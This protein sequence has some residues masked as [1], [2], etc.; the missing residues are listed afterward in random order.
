M[1]MPFAIALI[2][3]ILGSSFYMYREAQ[4]VCALPLSYRIGFIDERF[5]LSETEALSAIADA[6]RV[7]EQG[8]G[9]DIFVYQPE[10]EIEINFVYDEQQAFID[11]QETLLQKLDAS[12]SV[13]DAIDQT[14]QELEA[15]FR[16]LGIEYENR[17]SLHLQ[18]LDAYD[19][20]VAVFST[21]GTVSPEELAALET[22]QQWL[23]EE[24]A[25]INT[26]NAQ[27]GNLS[28]QINIIS[29]RSQDLVERYNQKNTV[30]NDTFAGRQEFMPGHYRDRT[31]NINQFQNESSL[32]LVLTHELGHALSLDHVGIETAV[33]FAYLGAQSEPLVLDE[34]D[35]LEFERVC[36]ATTRSLIERL[37]IR[38]G[39]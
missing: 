36:G 5:G 11:D 19:E 35:I 28:K 38:F 34:A 12:L 10:G 1:R 20:K 39:L 37:F 27:L 18:R 6:E 4:T 30:Y 31:I 9:A 32:Q 22:E 8:I 15:E 25:A 7:W 21:A 33:L 3:T 17:V 29:E 24:Q 16:N 23:E 14:Y 26:L 13:Q 2:I